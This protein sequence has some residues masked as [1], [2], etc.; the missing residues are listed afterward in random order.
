[1]VISAEPQPSRPTRGY[2]IQQQD[3]QKKDTKAKKR[4][5]QIKRKTVTTP[6][7][8]CSEVYSKSKAGEGWT[9]C[10]ECDL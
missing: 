7:L 6:C 10:G 9:K 1:M 5:S 2:R 8:Y 4:E 3:I